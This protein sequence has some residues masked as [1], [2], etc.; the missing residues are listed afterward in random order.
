MATNIT[1]D[2]KLSSYPRASLQTQKEGHRNV[3][4]RTKV[5]HR[6]HLPTQVRSSAS[7]R[8]L[9]TA[10]IPWILP[11]SYKV[12][13]TAI[14]D[15]WGSKVFLIL[16]VGQSLKR[17]TLSP[18]EGAS[19]YS[20]LTKG[21]SVVLSL[22]GMSIPRICPTFIHQG[23]CELFGVFFWGGDTFGLGNAFSMPQTWEGAGGCPGINYYL[24]PLLP[25]L[26]QGLPCLTN[27]KLGV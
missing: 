6:K 21:K 27:V 8:T 15:S 19:V 12:L 17:K 25:L 24:K 7:Y 3:P 1:I 23:G 16:G 22:H 4:F 14:S 5:Q 2:F 9:S 10:R 13:S 20:P 18:S 26:Y 11:A